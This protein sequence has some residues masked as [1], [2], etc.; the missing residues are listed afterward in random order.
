MRSL[1]IGSLLLATVCLGCG[2]GSGS[3]GVV[4]QGT[5]TERGTGHSK[6]VQ[7]AAK[8]SSGQRIGEV[9][10]CVLGACSITDDMGQWGVNVG[11]FAGG[12]VA[13]V[14]EGHGIN[15]SVSAH[16]PADTKEVEIDIDHAGNKLSVAKLLV[17]G[18]D[19]TDHSGHDHSEHDHAGDNHSG[20][21]H[22]G[23]QQ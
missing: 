14:L 2:G 13:L 8:H 23:A 15:A 22:K 16:I 9:K 3:D 19:H 18:E 12:D 11:E 4:F 21:D 6:S 10:V 5:L 7:V 20:H 17:D 1:T